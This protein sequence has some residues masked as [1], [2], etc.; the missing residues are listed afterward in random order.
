MGTLSVLKPYRRHNL[1]TQLLAWV[2]DKA[3]N[4]EGEDHNLEEI[5]L[6]VQTSNEAAIAFYKTFDFEV[7]EEI[8]NYYGG[9]EPPDCYVLR[10][11]LNRAKASGEPA[12][13]GSG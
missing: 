13:E 9:L 11:K 5:Y 1:S 10:R 3:E 7:A 6:H 8:K 2:I 12:A 4:K